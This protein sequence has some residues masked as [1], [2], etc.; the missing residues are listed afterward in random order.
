MDRKHHWAW[1]YFSGSRVTKDQLKLHFR[2]EYAVYV[3]DFPVFLARLYAHNPPRDVRSLLAENIYEED[4]GRLSLGRSHPD[5]FL[6]MM[7]GLGYHLDEFRDVELIP[8]G[9]A[10]REWLEEIA[11]RPCWVVGAAIMTVL[12]EGSVK[13]RQELLRPPASKSTEEIEDVV[14]KHPL[15]V[16]HGVTPEHLDLIRAHQMVE[17]GHRHAAYH[18]VTRYANDPE[19]QQ[20]VLQAMEEGLSLW[21]RY[22]DGVASA[23]GLT[24]TQ[25]S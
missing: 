15:A 17:T 16:Y 23:C 11:S 7:S 18:I 1:P 14:R 22:R 4:T 25:I 20:A 6:A 9:R 21:L 13:D 19:T 10:Y 5:L 2:Q 24:P 8:S 3:R 12:V